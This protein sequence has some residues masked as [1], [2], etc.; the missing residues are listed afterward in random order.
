MQRISPF[1]SGCLANLHPAA[2]VY[3]VFFARAHVAQSAFF[4]NIKRLFCTRVKIFL[5]S[6]EKEVFF[7]RGVFVARLFFVDFFVRI[8]IN[9]VGG[10]FFVYSTTHT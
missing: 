7:C 10:F 2:H 1:S 8:F 9:S 4:F 6:E 5:D 3:G